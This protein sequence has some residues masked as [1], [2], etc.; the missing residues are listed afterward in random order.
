MATQRVTAS[1][2][3]YT[4][5]DSVAK[6]T[7]GTTSPSIVLSSAVGTRCTL[8]AQCTIDVSS[9]EFSADRALTLKLRKTSGTAGDISDTTVV[10]PLGAIASSGEWN[11]ALNAYLPPTAYRVSAAKPDTIELWA[12]LD[13]LPD[14][15]NVFITA[16]MIL[17]ET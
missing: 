12:G 9:A 10:V 16:A 17:S 7:F 14:G 5:T 8:F 2:T 4:V 1:G 15:G 11:L 6:V 3:P 13:S